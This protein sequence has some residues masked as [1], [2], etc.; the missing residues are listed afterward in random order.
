MT[1]NRDPKIIDEILDRGV[2][3]NILPTKEDFKKLLLA[4]KRIKIY[5]GFDATADTLHLSHAKN[6]MLLADFRRPGHATI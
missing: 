2:I 4:G 1:I 5:I 6:I 3:S